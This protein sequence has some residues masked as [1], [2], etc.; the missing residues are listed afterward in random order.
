ML[1]PSALDGAIG[2]AF[3]DACVASAARDGRWVSARSAG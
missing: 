2:I 1:V 3:V